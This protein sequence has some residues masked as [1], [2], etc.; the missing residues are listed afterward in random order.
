VD[1][2]GNAVSAIQSLNAAFGSGVIAGDTGILMNN[3]MAYWHLEEGHA[4]LLKPG[5]RVR[6]TMNAPMIFKDGKLWCVYGTP[7]ADNQ[8]QV[9]FQSAVAM[10][11]LG[12]DPQQAVEAPRW[13]SNQPGQ[14]ANYPHPGELAVS[15]E[16]RFPSSVFSEL[17]A[18]GHRV[19][20]IG[21]LDGP[22]NQQVIRLL[23]NG[24]RMAGSDPRRDGWAL[25]Y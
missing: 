23:D 15:L 19:I 4:N 25:A 1:S 2:D 16:D 18:R 24:V 20:R 12:Y 3:R 22:C 5:K 14:D 11:D 17:E 6:H 21:E 13:S 7:G 9:N 10:M 8:V